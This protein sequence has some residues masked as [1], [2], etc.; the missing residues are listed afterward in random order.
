MDYYFP[1]EISLYIHFPFCVKKCFYCDFDSV[2]GSRVTPEEY[3]AAVISEMA[4]RSTRLGA[5]E[6]N[7]PSLYI[8]GGTPSLM[9]PRL[10]EQLLE[11]AGEFFGLGPE[12]EITLEANPGTVTAATLAGYR[13][14]GVNRLSLGV[15]SFDDLL[16]QRLGRIHS[17]KEALDA[18]DAA[19][20]AGFSN[21]GIDLINGLPDQSLAMWKSSLETAVRVAPEHISAYGLSIEDGT[22]F[23]CMEEAGELPLP[24]EEETAAMFAVTR[25]ILSGHHYQHYEISNYALDGHRSR[26]NQVYWQRGNYLGFG[27]GAHSFLNTPDWGTRWVSPRLIATYLDAIGRGQLAEEETQVLT[28]REAIGEAFF[29]GL[30]LLEGVDLGHLHREFGSAI[31]KEFSAAISCLQ[32]QGLLMQTGNSLCLAPRA[33]IV[34]NQVFCRFV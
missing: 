18:Y 1:M 20:K 19:R 28:R 24:G 22:P 32:A 6:V 25:E 13:G 26:H 27:A 16:L 21:V 5:P 30:R 14:A 11:A 7:V 8:G 2:E 15:Q 4:L 3:V 10:V 9:A 33:V 34:A 12:A 29:L 17:A 23:A 31:N